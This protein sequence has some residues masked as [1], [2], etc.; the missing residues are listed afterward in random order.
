MMHTQ[1]IIDNLALISDL[2]YA[3]V[4]LAVVEDMGLRVVA[5]RRTTTAI[6]PEVTYRIGA[7]LPLDSHVSE[8]NQAS[9]M[10]GAETDA[11]L[12]AA[13][14]LASGHPVRGM[15][16]RTRINPNDSTLITYSTSADPIFDPSGHVR[17]VLIRD[18]A[19]GQL[20][21]PGRMEAEFMK[22][23]DELVEGL[24][25]GPLLDQEGASYSTIRRP[26][27]GVMRIDAQGII[28]YPSPNAVAIMR[29][30]N[31]GDRVRTAHASELPGGGFAIMTALGRFTAVNTEAIIAGRT[32]VYRTIGIES[33]AIVLVED[34][35]ELRAEQRS[36]R[37][38][39]ATIREV[40]HRVKNN[41]QTVSALLRMQ[42][43]RASNDETR[44]ALFEATARVNSMAAVH[45]LLSEHSPES[46]E[47]AAVVERVVSLT[48]A[49]MTGLTEPVDIKVTS[50][51]TPELES[52]TATTLA[53]ALTELVY[54]ALQHGGRN[55]QVVFGAE[56]DRFLLSV[57]DDGPGFVNDF[58]LKR[59]AHL[60][61]T[62]VETLVTQDLGGLL[63][64]STE[65]GA[66]V[67]IDVPLMKGS[68]SCES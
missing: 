28:I 22:M 67:T 49:S 6:G 42:A 17:A 8:E 40:H 54:N 2:G 34:V 45:E 60:G 61:L 29:M 65:K 10:L 14:A 5:A 47:F 16:E 1:N 58:D 48:L 32:L 56:G 57:A 64:C 7:L 51:P 43:R 24:S 55:I 4:S 63:T 20:T 35:T 37:A 15:R 36:V 46:L 27:D 21:A 33:G 19:A 9:D 39:E 18:V 44:A 26:G 52:A 50:R 62:I 30:A 12:E 59:D 38:K 53:M 41:L 3:S 31:Y 66:R 25:H 11:E 68:D 23:T 13:E